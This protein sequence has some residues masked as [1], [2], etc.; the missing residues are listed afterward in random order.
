MLSFDRVIVILG[1]IFNRR[2]FFCLSTTCTIFQCVD[3]SIIFL[4]CICYLENISRTPP[5]PYGERG[6]I[7]GS[8][9]NS[10]SVVHGPTATHSLTVVQGPSATHGPT[11]RHGL[12]RSVKFGI[13]NARSVGNK[14][15][16]IGSTF[17]KGAY[18]VFLLTKTWRTTSE[19]IAL[20]RCVPPHY[21]CLDVPRST[22]TE[23]KANHGG[24][25]AF[26]SS[27]LR[28]KTIAPP[29]KTTTFESVCF[30]GTGTATTVTVL[31]LYRPGSVAVTDEFFDELTAYL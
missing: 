1:K 17:E 3:K 9:S 27:G 13:L 26:I 4:P 23:A 15:T 7:L 18:D 31:L 30:T 19:D 10:P 20:R 25:A 6:S 5:P 22:T 8:W 14:S 21:V 11:V 16:T 24:D 12:L 28:Y 2:R 29:L